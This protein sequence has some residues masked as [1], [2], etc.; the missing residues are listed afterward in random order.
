MKIGME[1][2]RGLRYKLRMTGIGISGPLYIY[3]NNM[4]VIHNTQRPEPMLKKKSNSI[5]YRTVRE[6]VVMGESLT[7]HIG[8]NEIVGDLATQVLYGQKRQYMISQLLYDIYTECRQL[9]IDDSHHDNCR[10]KQ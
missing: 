2:L 1:S 6:S 4:L 8:M 3:G 9:F 7:G 5:C 10:A